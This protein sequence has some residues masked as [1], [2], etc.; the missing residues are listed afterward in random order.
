MGGNCLGHGLMQ[1][2]IFLGYRRDDTG[3]DVGR[4]YDRLEGVVGKERLF[5]DVDSMARGV[6]FREY[7]PTVIGQCS[8]FLAFIGSR[9]L[10]MRDASGLR[11]LD[12]PEDLVRIEIETALAAS[13]IQFIPVLVA[14]AAMPHAHNLPLS[15]RP[16]TEFN[17]AEV[18]RDPD[19]N[20]DIRRLIQDLRVEQIS[21][22]AEAQIT[23]SVPECS[24]EG[25]YQDNYAPLI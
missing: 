20:S 10:E 12:D 17:C 7:I 9:W 1:N 25:V 23:L 3:G 24:T 19:F 14:G 2:S 5:R 8:V 11:R 15:L 22:K 6:K 21:R 13:N 16:M 18:R 4:I